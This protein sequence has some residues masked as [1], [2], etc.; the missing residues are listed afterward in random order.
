MARFAFFEDR[1][2]NRKITELAAEAS[3]HQIVEREEPARNLASSL[4]LLDRIAQGD[5][6]PL[7]DAYIVDADLGGGP[8]DGATIVRRIHELGLPGLVIGN[9]AS[10][11][12]Y[13]LAPVDRDAQKD[14]FA[15]MDILDEL[16]LRQSA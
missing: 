10:P 15:A 14:A 1:E 8:E 13:D 3:G 7:P 2:P 11:W 9:S 6:Q 16:S 5:I 4:H 12:N